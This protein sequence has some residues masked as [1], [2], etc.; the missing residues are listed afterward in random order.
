MSLSEDYAK[1]RT[2]ID[3]MFKILSEFSLDG[4]IDY[5]NQPRKAA[6]K[7]EEFENHYKFI[8]H[9]IIKKA[10]MADNAKTRERFLKQNLAK[11]INFL[12]SINN[13]INTESIGMDIDPDFLNKLNIISD[14][15]FPKGT[16][17]EN[18]KKIIENEEFLDMQR[19]LFEVN[20]PDLSTRSVR[21]DGPLEPNMIEILEALV[22]QFSI[23]VKY[24]KLPDS[25]SN[26]EYPAISR[27][28]LFEMFPAVLLRNKT[29]ENLL[30]ILSKIK[31]SMEGDMFYMSSELVT[32]LLQY[33]LIIDDTIHSRY[34]PKLSSS[35]PLQ[36]YLALI[37]WRRKNLTKDLANQVANVFAILTFLY[38][39]GK[40]FSVKDGEITGIID[41]WNP[42]Y[43]LLFD[44]GFQSRVIARLS[45]VLAHPQ[46]LDLDFNQIDSTKVKARHLFGL[47]TSKQHDFNRFLNHLMSK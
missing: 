35:T 5:L 39:I 4:K 15:I 41:E 21:E 28:S 34:I 31:F 40:Y 6:T 10:D 33:G 20:V 2:W 43:Q 36:L 7:D 42:F 9:Q 16:F 45:K 13:L 17:P 25:S 23:N 27:E 12:K 32:E 47:L 14:Y 37:A 26:Y 24:I 18:L 30:K 19:I 1:Y 11:S 3:K 22:T 29:E 8:I 46:L 44:L 38:Y